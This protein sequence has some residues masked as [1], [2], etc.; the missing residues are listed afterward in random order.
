LC[1]AGGSLAA[2]AMLVSTPG[3]SQMLGCTPLGPVGWAQALGCAAAATA[4]S[5]VVPH[6]GP[7]L[8]AV[9]AAGIQRTTRTTF[10]RTSK[11]YMPRTAGSKSAAHPSTNPA[12]P[13]SGAELTESR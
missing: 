11:A 13:G 8:A 2:L 3:V 10:Q 6:V 12:G 7:R 4:V 1:T 5:A 9:R